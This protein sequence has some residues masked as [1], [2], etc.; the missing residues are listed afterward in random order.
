MDYFL[1]LEKLRYYFI[2]EI[3]SVDA[4]LLH[5]IDK[6][7]QQIFNLNETFGRLA[8]VLVGDPRQIIP[9]SGRACFTLINTYP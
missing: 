7:L 3:Y 9:V 6:R 1:C 8:V 5:V 2:D 4:G